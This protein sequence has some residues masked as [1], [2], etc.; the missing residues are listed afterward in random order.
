MIVVIWL[1]GDYARRRRGAGETIPQINRII[2]NDADGDDRSLNL[3]PASCEYNGI[4]SIEPLA[5]WPARHG[6]MEERDASK[7]WHFQGL[8]HP[9]HLP[10]RPERGRGLCDRARLR[11][12]PQGRHG[13]GWARYAPLRPADVRRGHAWD[14]GP[15]RG[16]RE[17]RHG[18]HRPVLLR[19]L[20]G[21]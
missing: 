10:D 4:S 5:A 11:Q 13:G 16:R 21:E 14:H 3:R 8:R 15:G 17:H 12:L 20:A 2:I 19:L 9:R 6:S 18:Q 7:P 1:R